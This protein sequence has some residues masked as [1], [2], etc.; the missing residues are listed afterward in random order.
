MDDFGTGHSS[1]EVLAA[2]PFDTLKIDRSFVIRSSDTAKDRALL[3]ALI[4]LAHDVGM[5]VVAEGVE[6]REQL[7]LLRTL[8]AD[9]VQGF[10]YA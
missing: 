4:S 3:A 6:T 9:E 8:G 2:Y 7:L 5:T 1:L 10:F